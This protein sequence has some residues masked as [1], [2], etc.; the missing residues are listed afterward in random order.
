MFYLMYKVKIIK[1]KFYKQKTNLAVF[2]VLWKVIS[3][4]SYVVDYKQLNNKISWIVII[5]PKW[6][7][8]VLCTYSYISIKIY[9]N[10][11]YL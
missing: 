3:K 7:K 1:T 10:N 6:I 9:I 5:S 4:K 8:I 11:I 2:C